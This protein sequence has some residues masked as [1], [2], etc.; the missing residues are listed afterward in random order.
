MVKYSEEFIKSVVNDRNNYPNLSD[1]DYCKMKK[2]SVSS[3][4]IW[5]NRLSKFNPN[6]ER[7]QDI[8]NILKRAENFT[9]SNVEFCRKNKINLSNFNFWRNK[10]KHL[11]E[12]TEEAKPLPEKKET[13]ETKPLPK[14]K[15]VKPLPKK[16]EVKPSE[17]NSFG[18]LRLEVKHMENLLHSY[19]HDTDNLKNQIQNLTE[20]NKNLEELVSSHITETTGKKLILTLTTELQNILKK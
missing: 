11:L 7:L 17:I 9:G 8:L 19:I 15:E 6:L 20:R 3:F 12:E 2:I 10:Y 1:Y 5:K 18:D 16:K 14:K 13:E 4:H